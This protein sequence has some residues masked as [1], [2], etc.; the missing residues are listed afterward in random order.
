LVRKHAV[1]LYALLPEWG[2]GFKIK[3]ANKSLDMWQLEYLVIKKKF[4]ITLMKKITDEE[5]AKL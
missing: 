2:K 1:K 5:I 3:S 4:T